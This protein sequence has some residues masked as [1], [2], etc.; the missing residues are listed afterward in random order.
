[1]RILPSFA[2]FLRGV[3]GTYPLAASSVVPPSSHPAAYNLIACKPVRKR[4]V[5]TLVAHG[6][7][8][9]EATLESPAAYLA[10]AAAVAPGDMVAPSNGFLRVV[11]TD[12]GL[13]A[14]QIEVGGPLVGTCCAPLVGTCGPLVGTCAPLV[15]T[16]AP[17]A[18]DA[19]PLV[20]RYFCM[21]RMSRYPIA[22]PS[23]DVASRSHVASQHH[24]LL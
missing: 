12:S 2:P 3:E 7:Q 9:G 18:P 14:H 1:M 11:A 20:A 4:V 15:G 16:C 21:S 24:I 19:V 13:E 6:S 17:L 22:H 23:C 10:A 5:N 8:R